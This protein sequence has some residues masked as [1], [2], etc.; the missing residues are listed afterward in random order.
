MDSGGAL[1]SILLLVA[2]VSW[3]VYAYEKKRRNP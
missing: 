3:G 2:L 1:Y